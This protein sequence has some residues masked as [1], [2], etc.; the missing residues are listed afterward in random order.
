MNLDEQIETITAQI[1]FLKKDFEYHVE[2]NQFLSAAAAQGRID[3]LYELINL[4]T[5]RAQESTCNNS[6]EH[7]ASESTHSQDSDS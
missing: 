1:E 3:D 6:P 4:L 2:T 5:E 7:T